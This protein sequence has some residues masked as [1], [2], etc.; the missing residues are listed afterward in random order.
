M[1]HISKNDQA[2]QVEQLTAALQAAG[3]GT[4]DYNLQT[5]QAQ[6]SPVCKQLFGLPAEAELTAAR[7]LE[8]VHPDDRPWVQQANLKALSPQGHQHDITFR[9]LHP[10]GEVRWVH[11]LGRTYQNEQG[12]VIRFSGIVQDVTQQVNAQQKVA[13][14]QRELLAL[15]EQAPVG[16]ATL[17]ADEHLV[18][19]WANAF[20]GKLVARPPSA[21]IGRPLLEVL[22]E[23]SGQGFDGILKEVV[24]TGQ[25]F[26]APEVPVAIRRHGQLETI[27]V[28]LTYQPQRD[29]QEAVKSILVVATDVTQ[30]VVSRKKV[31]DSETKLRAILA[32]AP[33]GIGLFVGRDLVIETP[34]QTFIDIVG[35]GPGI[36]GLPLREAMPELITEGQPFLQILDDVFTTGEPFLSPGSLVR[37]V[38]NGVLKDNFYNISYTPVRNA[39]G[40]V[41]AI[42]D[43][44][45]DVTAQVNAHQQLADSEWFSRSIIEHSPVAK[46]VCVGE[47]M[48]IERINPN[49]LHL[50]GLDASILGKPLGEVVPERVANRLLARLR[51]VLSTG[52]TDTQA[53]ETLELIRFGQPYT[54]YY[55]YTVKA[56]SNAAGER[57]GVIVT[58]SEVTQQVETRKRLEETQVNLHEAIKLAQLGTWELE[59]TTGQVH[60]SNTIRTWFGFNEPA[61]SY[62]QV[63]EPIH[64]QD[65]QRVAKAIQQ[66]LEPGSAGDYEAEYRLL[67]PST[68]QERV[69]HARGKVLYNEQGAAYKVLGTAQ[70]V[71]LDR[72][73]QLALEKQVQQRTEELAAA[74][75]ELALTNEELAAANEDYGVINKELEEANK[76]LTRSNENLQTFAYVASHDLQEPLR[77]IQ[78]FGDLL[79]QAYA[80]E[81]GDGVTYLK[82]MQSAAA[83][84]STLIKDLLEFS[85]ISTQ[86]ESSGPV[87]LHDVVK[88]VLSTLDLSI[89]ETGAQVSVEPLP[90]VLGDATQLGQLFQN[91]LTNAL[92]FSRV[93]A[94]GAPTVPQIAITTLLVRA[95]ELP[96]EVT[97]ARLVAEYYRI[98]VTDNGIGFEDKYVDRIFQ[99][100]QR[101]HGKN[102]FAGTGVGLAICEKV[103][104]NHGGAITARSRPGQGA[105]FQVYL[106]VLS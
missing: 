57:Y 102:Q 29:R 97:P 71:T 73:L 40:E 14:S 105:T 39:A 64:P 60:Y 25:P 59:L 83:R 63:F 41:Y 72:A 106:P 42:L 17:S 89:Q 27:F 36:E 23:I 70:D 76:L 21:L 104:Q 4:W 81:L 54:G 69:L 58:A 35:K 2:A 53:E 13:D 79:Q 103:V 46:V 32:A 85:R 26:M 51:Q 66:A 99:V 11:A 93:D 7:L 52:E 34:N 95:S 56:L 62:D 15:F 10:A 37:I 74:N 22:P 86:R 55:Q 50:L 100:F 80:D 84:M 12:Q 61:V 65:R 8:Q 75:E 20:Y 43:I 24:A 98:D 92:K 44:A 96:A 78:Q 18:F 87:W 90:R 16:V 9:T 68:G 101:L 91:L 6:W 31:E 33:A 28:N 49:M 47:Q 48:R 3:V 82:R 38:Q 30:Q 5:S 67:N 19:Q 1:A 77:K 94:T 45:I 88:Q